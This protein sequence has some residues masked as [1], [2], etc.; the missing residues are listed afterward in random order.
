MNPDE[1]FSILENIRLQL[2]IDYNMKIDDER[3]ISQIIHNIHPILQ[4]Q[5]TL[6]VIKRDMNKGV[7]TTLEEIKEELR[8]VYGTIKTGRIKGETALAAAG[9]GPNKPK[10]KKQF[11]G[12][13]NNCGAYGHKAIDCPKRGG[14]NNPRKK[15]HVQFPK[16]DYAQLVNADDGKDPCSYCQKAGHTIKDC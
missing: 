11:K 13:C 16:G 5:T 1:W 9:K 4:Y 12:Q 7:P 6:T 15:Q 2:W 14:S 10:F 8:Q 3:M